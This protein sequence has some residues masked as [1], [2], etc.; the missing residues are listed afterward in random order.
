M[1]IYTLSYTKTYCALRE[2]V[3]RDKPK[4][5]L[6]ASSKGT[7]PVL[8]TQGGKIIDE[9]LDIML[10]ALAKNDP[11]GW[12]TS[13][14]QEILE[15]VTLNDGLFKKA[16][17]RYKYPDRFENVSAVQE[18]ETACEIFLNPLENRLKKRNFL[19]YDHFCLADAAIAPFVRQFS[20][21]DQ[22]WWQ[23]ETRFLHVKKWLDD[24]LDSTLFHS[25][26]TKYDPWGSGEK[27]PTFPIEETL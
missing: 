8:V 1:T 10:W 27:E 6:E 13:Q 18:R 4:E 12:Y 24:F 14:K 3:L 19:L 11:D 2:V 5:L 7:V 16:L 22:E 25:V 20:K 26:M 15:L 9:S 21:V 23:K 17:D